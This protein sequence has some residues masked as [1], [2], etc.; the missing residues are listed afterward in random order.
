[1]S[2]EYEDVSAVNKR[3]DEA[4]LIYGGMDLHDLAL[5][6]KDLRAIKDDLEDRLKT[7]N[8][9]YDLLRIELIPA[10]MENEGVERVTYE[11]IGRVNLTGDLYVQVQNKPGLMDWLSDE[12]MGDLIQPTVN[13][14]TLKAFIKRRIAAGQ[15]I[16]EEFVKVS[17]FTRASIT[18]S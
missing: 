12:G 13:S 17:P 5:N 2:D 7:V 3:K 14:S 4:R 15:E 11:G 1:M 16:P 10:A 6:M 18:K 8:A 9:T